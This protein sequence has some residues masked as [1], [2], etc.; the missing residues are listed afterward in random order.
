MHHF[1][2][3]ALSPGRA[4]SANSRGRQRGLSTSVHNLLLPGFWAI[5]T[6]CVIL[7]A[8]YADNFVLPL[9]P[10]H[11][12]PMAKYKLLRDR[13]ASELPEVQLRQAPAASDGELALVHEPACI[14][15]ITHGTLAAPAQR[16]IGFPWS[17]GM[18]ERAR[19]KSVV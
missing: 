1:R 11:R 4:S 13:V 14:D 3:G 18:S 19:R 5:F 7:Q 2:D 12:F 10:G 8:F 16:E 6:G 17:P 15:A 9:P